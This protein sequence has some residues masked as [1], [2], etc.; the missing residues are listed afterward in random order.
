MRT[1]TAHDVEREALAKE[2]N[3]LL[4][5]LSRAYGLDG[6]TADLQRLADLGPRVM[7][8]HDRYSRWWE[9]API[10]RRKRK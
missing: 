4:L 3:S 7:G 9:V 8:Y 1:R 5:A 6:R 2:A 10:T